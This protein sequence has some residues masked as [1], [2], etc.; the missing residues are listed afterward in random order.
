[1][2]PNYLHLVQLRLIMAHRTEAASS[3]PL[4]CCRYDM[5]LL[6]DDHTTPTEPNMLSDVHDIV[7]YVQSTWGATPAGDGELLLR[8][9]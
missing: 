9:Y 5:H 6:D 2:L 3:R 4:L 8:F 7:R 1:M